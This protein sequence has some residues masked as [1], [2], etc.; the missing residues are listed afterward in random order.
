MEKS[1]SKEI[2][3]PTHEIWLKKALQMQPDE[4]G[5]CGHRLMRP[6]GALSCARDMDGGRGRAHIR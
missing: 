1:R 2:I 4:I 6:A 5:Q 3:Q